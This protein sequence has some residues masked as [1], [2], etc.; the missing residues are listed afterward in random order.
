MTARAALLGVLL[1]LGAAACDRESR[2]FREVPPATVAEDAVVLNNQN[3][4][5][6][7][8]SDPRV[9]NPYE[10]TA[11]GVAEGQRLYTQWNCAG[12]HGPRG[13]GNIGPAL[14]D[15]VWIYGAAP[16]NIVQALV[17][18]RPNGMPA[19]RG[20]INTAD[21]WKIAAHVRSTAGLVG[22]YQRSGRREGIRLSTPTPQDSTVHPVEELVPPVE[23]PA[24][25]S[26]LARVASPDSQRARRA[27]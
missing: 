18:G 19:F 15:S 10:R 17:E 21:M 16:E 22:A 6:P 25:D 8:L 1:A 3:Q 23:R 24:A 11:W 7:T 2:R 27:P 4:A 5:G 20:R 26:A 12:C 13:G 14:N 9:E